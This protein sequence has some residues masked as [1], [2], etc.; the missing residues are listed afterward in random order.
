MHVRT[1][2]RH[3][4]ACVLTH[5]C[6]R[7][8]NKTQERGC[9]VS[10]EDGMRQARRRVT[11][12]NSAPFARA[13]ARAATQRVGSVQK[14][15]VIDAGCSSRALG[16]LSRAWTGAG[17]GISGF[18]KSAGPQCLRRDSEFPRDNDLHR[19]PWPFES[20]SCRSGMVTVGDRKAGQCLAA[21]LQRGE[22][23]GRV[24]VGGG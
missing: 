8:E 14:S 9:T 23:V 13:G 11:E 16:S 19:R 7:A 15:S 20:F 22:H 24:P 10:V 6:R 21:L 12:G 2:G 1:M 5:R 17:S 18:V 3:H 4:G